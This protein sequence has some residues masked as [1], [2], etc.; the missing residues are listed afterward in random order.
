MYVNG[1]LYKW[2]SSEHGKTTQNF[3][4]ATY[5]DS[6]SCSSSKDMNPKEARLQYF[7]V[8]KI[9]FRFDFASFSVVLFYCK[10]FRS[11]LVGKHAT[12]KIDKYGF[13]M[14]D[15]TKLL[16]STE[17]IDQP[18]VLPSHVHQVFYVPDLI[19]P[20]WS[21]VLEHMP[22]QRWI[23]GTDVVDVI[24]FSLVRDFSC[25]FSFPQEINVDK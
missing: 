14:V 19:E 5:F 13:Q 17:I 10:W 4:V 6:L 9:I 2:E 11:I 18:F 21:V 23:V 15:T 25:P 12:M 1:C 20:N 24:D 7:G 16:R 8:L 3:D 22:R